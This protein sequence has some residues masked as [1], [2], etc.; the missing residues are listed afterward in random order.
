VRAI[1]L[2]PGTAIGFH[3]IA[4]VIALLST[5]GDVPEG[6]W[7]TWMIA[8]LSALAAYTLYSAIAFSILTRIRG[9][10]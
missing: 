4:L 2:G 1:L 7:I 10:T 8:M 3:A 5:I 6:T 9:T